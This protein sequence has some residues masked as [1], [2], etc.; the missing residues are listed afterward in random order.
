MSIKNVTIAGSGVLGSQIAFQTAFRGYNVTIYDIN[1]D[2]IAK[3]K[4]RM[5]GLV[6]TYK[7]EVQ[8]QSEHL[9]VF[10]QNGVYESTILPNLKDT[11]INDLT[12]SRKN[13]EAV[14]GSI[15]YFTD[16]GK[17]VKGADLV[18]EAIPERMDIKESFYKELSSVAEEKT[19]FATNTSTLLPSQFA[20]LTGRKNKFLALHFANEIWKNNTAEV[21]GTQWTDKD[22][23]NEVV[24]FAKGIG[25]IPIELKKEQPGYVLNTLL[26]PLLDAAQM[27]LAKGVADIETIDKTWMLATKAP[28]GPFGILDIVGLKTAYDITANAAEND[29][30]YK[31]LAD[32]IKNDYIDKG[33]MGVATGEGFYKYPNPAYKQPDFLS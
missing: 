32:M 25:M 1:D 16:L 31:E 28:F 14:P 5:H 6:D 2:V 22:I 18:I 13:A 7:A 11:L 19:I 10:L 24:E 33:K 17:A 4:D 9:T 23:Y 27:L 12:T 29:P 21:M 8:D 30:E 15:S 20:D 3:A 26:V